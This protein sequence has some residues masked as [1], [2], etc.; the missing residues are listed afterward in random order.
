[1][2]LI[3]AIWLS[4][5]WVIALIE[6]NVKNEIVKNTLFVSLGA[7]LTICFMTALYNV[8]LLLAEQQM[9]HTNTAR[10][11][12]LTLGLRH[13][14]FKLYGR[15]NAGFVIHMQMRFKIKLWLVVRWVFHW[16]IKWTMNTF[17]SFRFRFCHVLALEM[18]V[19]IRIYAFSVFFST[20]D[21]SWLDGYCNRNCSEYYYLFCLP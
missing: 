8:I 20:S 10:L 11:D 6:W 13:S 16:A 18:V 21:T 7:K 12:C 17:N 3:S 14:T 4:R 2:H 19:W 5:W 1:M 15:T 9:S